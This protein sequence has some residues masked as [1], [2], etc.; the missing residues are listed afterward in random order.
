MPT[1]FDP[2]PIIVHFPIAL[3]VASALFELVG[4]A[5]DV[6]WWRKAAFAMLIV[7]V[8][9]AGAAVLSGQRAEEAAE[10]QGVP[11]EPLEEHEDAAMFVLYLGAA[12]VVVRAVAGRTGPA[13]GAVGLV[14]LLLHLAVAGAV[15]RAGLLGGDLVYEHGAGVR[16]AALSIPSAAAPA[17]PPLPGGAPADTTAPPR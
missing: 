3:I 11:E 7:G 2:H 16:S 17:P 8:L 9:G 6:V 14:G 10:R 12:A 15:G 1:T 13:A 4:R 5:T